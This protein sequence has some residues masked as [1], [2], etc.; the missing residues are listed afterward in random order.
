MKKICLV[1]AAAMLS[2]MVVSAQENEGRSKKEIRKEAQ[3]M[4]QAALAEEVVNAINDR[5]FVLEIDKVTFRKGKSAFTTPRTNFIL[6]NGD[7]AIVQLSST[8]GIY[9]TPN[10]IGGITVEGRPTNVNITTDKK[11]NLNLS[12]SVQGT[13]ISAQVS[14]NVPKNGNRGI[15]TIVPNFNRARITLKGLIYPLEKS[16]IFKGTSLN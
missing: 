16:T 4:T 10:G 13:A 14:M 15:A 1:L 9:N 11:G 2:G 3:E 8:A 7:N 5:R 12:M 6:L